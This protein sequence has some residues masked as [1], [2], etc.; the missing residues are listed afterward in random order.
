[1]A[2]VQGDVVIDIEQ[3]KGCELCNVACPLNVLA[4]SA[5]VNSKGYH[6][7]IKVNGNCNGCSNCAVVCPDGVITV[8]R[9]KV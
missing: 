4:I 2:K 1:M 3:C 8:Y 7:A 5:E 6:Y 9:A